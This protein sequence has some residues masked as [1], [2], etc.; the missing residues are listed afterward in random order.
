V[1]LKKRGIN[2]KHFGLYFTYLPEAPHGRIFTKFCTAV[3]AMDLITC[4]KFFIDRLRY[5]DYVG[6]K[7]DGSQGFPLTKL[8]AVNTGPARDNSGHTGPIFAIFSPYEIAICA[9]DGSVPHF[10]GSLPWQTN[11]IAKM[12]STPTD[13]TCVRCTSARKRIAI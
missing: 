1:F 8:M 7:N 12:L 6:V 13:I 3:E 10:Q 5:V 2:K 11:N 9:D 4:D